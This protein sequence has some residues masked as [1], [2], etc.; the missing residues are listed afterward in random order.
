MDLIQFS[1]LLVIT[2][3]DN[4]FRLVAICDHNLRLIFSD[5]LILIQLSITHKQKSMRNSAQ[6]I[7]MQSIFL[8]YVY[9]LSNPRDFY[10]YLHT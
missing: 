5:K 3:C 7:K 6:P 10:L 1:N 2:I 4:L 9:E 8:I